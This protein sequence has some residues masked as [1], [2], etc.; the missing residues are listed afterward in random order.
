MVL[1]PI[2][3]RNFEKNRGMK[4]LI[5]AASTNNALGKDNDLLWHLPNDFK[6]F[7]AL[8]TDE[9]KIVWFI[10]LNWYFFWRFVMLLG[11]EL[12]YILPLSPHKRIN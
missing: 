8:T 12:I 2:K 6:R 10:E 3:I 7:K 5:A 9:V 1:K 4:I 11:F